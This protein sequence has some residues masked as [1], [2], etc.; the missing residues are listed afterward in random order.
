VKQ[1]STE[2]LG[3]SLAVFYFPRPAAQKIFEMDEISSKA[4]SPA[5]TR[6]Q[7]ENVTVGYSSGRHTK[8]VAAQDISLSVA[9]GEFAAIIG[10]SGCGKSTLLNAVAG[11]IEPYS[12]RIFINGNVGTSRLGH[13]AYMQQRDLLLPWR[14]VLE[15]AR[16]ALEIGGTDRQHAN[17]AASALAERFGLNNVL[18]RYPWQLSGGMRQRAAL[19][20]S[21]LQHSGILL[22]DEPFGA[23]DALTRRD[24]QQWLA[25]VLDRRDRAV[26][27]VTHDVEEALLLADRVYVMSPGPGTIA[28]TVEVQLSRPRGEEIVTSPEFVALKA[29]LLHELSAAT[30]S[31]F[32][33]VGASS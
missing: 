10:P 24:L 17:E 5:M 18:D 12:G 26:L 8:V 27:L 14:T 3:T 29:A 7:V 20:R 15:N 13:V 33:A 9:A 28:A 4:A 30:H 32:A 31:G 19:L 23:L 2:P 22:L 1:L 21:S 6:L 25:T 16:I 11:L